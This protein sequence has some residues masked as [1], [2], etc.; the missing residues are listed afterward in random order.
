M[1]AR[2]LPRCSPTPFNRTG[3]ENKI[4]KFVGQN[5]DREFTYRILPW[6][7]QTQGKLI[8]C[9]LKIVRNKD[10]IKTTFPCLLLSWGQLHSFVPDS[11]TSSLS[12]PHL[13]AQGNAEQELW[14][15]HSTFSAAP[16]SSCFSPAPA[17]GLF[18][19]VQ[20]FTNSS[21]MEPSQGLQ[22]FK[23]CTSVGLSVM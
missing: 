11:Y 13:V 16:S 3:G 22:F 12:C 23:N 10:K 2:C 5:K 15:V 19:R 21:D 6:A 17:C 8:Y 7:K 20:S 18:H 14:P 1:A 9:Q 4:K